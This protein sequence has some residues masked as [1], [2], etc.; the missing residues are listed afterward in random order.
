MSTVQQSLVAGMQHHQA[1]R[2]AEAET[3]Y[4]QALAAEPHNALALHQLGTL[5][6]DTGQLEQAAELLAAAVKADD[7]QPAY[8]AN[9]AVCCRQL[10][11]TAEA[12][13]ALRR[14][15]EVDARMPQLYAMLGNL[16]Q[17]ERRMAEAVECFRHV[18]QLAPQM[19]DAHFD[20]GVVLQMSGHADEAAASYEA[21]LKLDPKHVLTHVNLGT[22]RKRQGKLDRAIAHFQQALAVQPNNAAAL[23]NLGAAYELLGRTDE[24]LAAHRA[25]VAAGP[26]SCAAQCNLR[27]L[28]QKMGALDEAWECFRHAQQ[29]N[30]RYLSAYHGMAAVYYSRQ[31]LDEAL[32]TLRQALDVEPRDALTHLN[33]SRMLNEQGHRDEAMRS[34]QRALELDPGLPAAHGNLAIALHL[35]G[36]LDEALAEHRREVELNPHSALHHSNLLYCLNYHPGLEP[37]AV[38]EEHRAWGIRHADPLS[39]AAEPH[40]ND[41]S[42]ERRLKLGYVSPHFC[43][44]AVNFFAEPILAHHDHEAFEVFCYSDVGREDATTERLRGYADQW[45][46]IRGQ[47]HEQVSRRIRDDQIDILV[48]L[49]GHIGQNRMLAFARRPAPVQVSYLGYQNTTGMRAMDYRLTDAYA[50]PPGMTED[51]YTEKLVRLPRTFFCYQPSADAPPVG[52]P[53]SQ[54]R[55]SVTFGSFNSFAKVT[56]EVLETWAGILRM[57]PTARLLLLADMTDSVERYLRET[58]AR[59]GIDADRLELVRRLPR[60]EYLPAHRR[61]RHRARSVSVQRPHDHLRLPVAGRAGGLPFRPDVRLAVWRQRAGHAGLAR[62]DCRHQRG[63]STDRAG[64]VLRPGPAGAIADDVAR[65][66]GRLADH[67]LRRLHAQPRDRIPP[68]VA[69]LVPGHAR[70]AVIPRCVSL[71]PASRTLAIER[72]APGAS[73]ATL[74]RPRRP[75]PAVAARTSDA[76]TARARPPCHSALHAAAGLR[77]DRPFPGVAR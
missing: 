77:P 6:M 3:A 69:H 64:L 72:S 56:P 39:A 48:D 57:I 9:Y 51:W 46:T 75:R 60:P 47:G 62:T 30:P 40:T 53:P 19:A 42:P 71:G 70:Y 31:M 18:V 26:Q 50:D 23:T 22:L 10:N 14:A 73:T 58:F 41:R 29:V 52:V 25:A 20:L 12:E 2:H 16:L 54:L 1:G 35:Q 11:R 68:H 66:D 76:P 59:L 43:D 67:G 49:T 65:H 5:A 38:F 61:G 36:R 34:G 33:I 17:G 63:I 24:A 45:R 28:L 13:A 7:S 74:R 32:A 4:R 37:R 55:G 8:H 15:I 27:A 44:H 21:A